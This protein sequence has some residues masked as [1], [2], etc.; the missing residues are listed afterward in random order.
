MALIDG[1]GKP[2]PE[3][4]W[5]GDLDPVRQAICVDCGTPIPFGKFC[6]TCMSKACA[7]NKEIMVARRE[8]LDNEAQVPKTPNPYK[9]PSHEMDMTVAMAKAQER[10]QAIVTPGATVEP[11]TTDHLQK[12]RPA[13]QDTTG[14]VENND[15]SPGGGLVLPAGAAQQVGL[16]RRSDD[17]LVT[18][19]MMWLAELRGLAEEGKISREV[20]V[21]ALQATAELT[22]TL[23]CLLK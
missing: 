23:A 4:S 2:I 19:A 11:D 18:Q 13:P 12:A 21:E 1:E 10:A 22:Y 16:R 8:K 14:T 5:G 17:F 15:D 6:P 7:K 20:A 3:E 9:P